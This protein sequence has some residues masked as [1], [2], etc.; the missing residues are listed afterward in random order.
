MKYYVYELWD[1]AKGVPFYVGKGCGK[2]TYAHTSKAHLA[3]TCGNQFKKS[4]IRKMLNDN[5]KP[6]VKYVFRTDDELLAYAT[7]TELILYYGRRDIK[8]G[9]LTNL[10]NGGI[11][12]LN[13]NAESRYKMGSSRRGKK[14]TAAETTLRTSGLKGFVHTAESRKNMSIAKVGKIPACVSTRRSYAGEGNPQH[15]KLWDTDKKNKMSASIKGRK[16]SYN[17]DGTWFFIYPEKI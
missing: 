17:A 6:V 8:T 3:K 9:I 16:R 12:S 1:T 4:V 15:G 2:R 5:N 13:P 10:T 14:E 11:G 7:E